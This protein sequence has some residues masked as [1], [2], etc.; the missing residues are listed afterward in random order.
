MTVSL[1]L[2]MNGHA[3]TIEFPGSKLNVATEALWITESSN[4]Q[5]GWLTAGCGPN[6]L[7]LGNPGHLM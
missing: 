3:F 6:L 1:S 7:R 4:D 2:V 5:K